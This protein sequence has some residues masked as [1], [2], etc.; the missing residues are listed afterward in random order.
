MKRPR[1]F[2]GHLRKFLGLLPYLFR[3]VGLVWT[4]ARR[5]T[6]AWAVLLL[7]QGL[8]PAIVI[9]LTRMIIDQLSSTL[10]KGGGWTAVQPALI[11]VA[12]MAVILLVSEILRSLTQW[13]RA[14]QAELVQDYISGLIH[15]QALS[16]DLA[17][18]ETT[19][20]YDRLHRARV[21]AISRPLLLLENLGSLAQNGITLLALAGVLIS[22]SAWVPLVLIVS[23]LPALAVV[24]RYAVRF[25]DW[26][27]RNTAHERRVRYYDLLLTMRDAAAELRL[28]GLGGYFADSFKTL[29]RRLRTERLA[30]TRD[31]MLTEFWTG[32]ASLL[33]MAAAMMWMIHRAAT[34]LAGLGDIVLFYQ[35]FQQGRHLMRTLL[36]SIA[37]VYRNIMFL[38]DLFE[39]LSLQPQVVEPVPPTALPSRLQGTIRFER[40]SFR[41][42]ESNHPALDNFSLQIPIGGIAAL[43]G[44]NGAGKS[45]LIKL[46]CRLYDPDAGRITVGGIDLREVSP[47]DL[48]RHIT[49]LFQEPMH[50]HVSAEQNI[51]L[52]DLASAS[53][54]GRVEAA[55]RAAGAHEPISRL[56]QGYETV[57]GKWFG[58]AEL[59][60]GEWQRLAL[61]RAFLRQAP[62]VILD[63]PTSAMDSWAEADWLG[64]FRSLVA[65]RTAVIITHRFTTAMQAD[66]IHVMEAGRIIE[67]GTHAELAAQGG[68]YGQSWAE[69]MRGVQR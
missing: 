50:Y 31:Q 56:S 65:G 29:R 44:D 30:M 69:Q 58:G 19:E 49:V 37:D 54:P 4:A 64:R 10:H 39:F 32:S 8:L 47:Q 14:T 1:T 48:W 25:N 35:V 52:G 22:Y 59:S 55:A 61:A 60:V 40:V 57:L 12:V 36:E 15:A 53:I 63:E 7:V 41:Y 6:V 20:Y 38:E 18:Y 17:F 66:I 34:G 27:I 42:P 51:A 9:Y 68:R 62:I 5:W 2:S 16:L 26:R 23:T 67:T 24:A 11:P 33:I 21:D 3:A 46:M 28:F 13:V 45:T 43:V